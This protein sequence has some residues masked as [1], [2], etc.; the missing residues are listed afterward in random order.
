[1]GVYMYI[2]ILSTLQD[3]YWT[4]VQFSQPEAARKGMCCQMS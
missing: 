4:T 2:G 1:M 3:G